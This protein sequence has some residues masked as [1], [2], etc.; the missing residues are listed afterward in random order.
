MSLGDGRSTIAFDLR[1]LAKVK[2]RPSGKKR[3]QNA[4]LPG[5][6]PSAGAS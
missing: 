6:S 2:A 4:I 5:A 3:N 1:R